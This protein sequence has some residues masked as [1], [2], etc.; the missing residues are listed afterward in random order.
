MEL[1]AAQE[2]RPITVG[3][4][5]SLV[6]FVTKN[7]FF[8][9]IFFLPD[10][11][12]NLASMFTGAAIYFLMG[13]LVGRG[14]DAQV[15][16][17]GV[18]YGSYIVIGIMF[19]TVLQTSLTAYHQSLLQGYWA[20]QLNNYMLYPGGISAYLVG[21]LAA[22]YGLTAVNTLIYF[23]VGIWLFGVPIVVS[24]LPSVLLVLLLAMLAITGLGLAGASTFSLL[25]A[26]QW[27]ANP[28]E[29]LVTFGVS[30][31]SGVY[32]PPTVLP[33]WL[34]RA[35]DWLPQTHA[36]HAARLAL[37]GRASLADAPVTADLVF[38]LQ[39]SAVAVPIGLLLFSA[40][41]RKALREGTLTR[42]S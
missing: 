28:V 22:L 25:N 42:W 30:L 35:G 1:A 26:K 11:V 32:F 12:L 10:F 29:W 16:Q 34:Q 4:W 36:L 41:L 33:A 40:G 31:L 5:L 21:N 15:A 8:G 19:N 14:A 39:F 24:A 7:W 13:Q 27:G 20:N 18:T 6:L 37:S 17:Y 9:W 3:A 38:L 2:L 23:G